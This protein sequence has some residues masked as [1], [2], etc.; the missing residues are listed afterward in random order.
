MAAEQFVKDAIAHDQIV[1]F[2]KLSCGYCSMTKEIFTKLKATF[3]AIE[4]DEREDMDAIQDALQ[5]IT[6]AR[7]VPRVFINGKFIGGGSDVKKLNSNGEL[8][9]LIN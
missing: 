5:E 9:K 4:L 2:S 3:K 7:S 6:G 8:A 1:I